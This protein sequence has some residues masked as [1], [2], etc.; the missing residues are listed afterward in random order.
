MQVEAAVNENLA[1]LLTYIGAFYHTHT[2]YQLTLFESAA[3][4]DEAMRVGW[5]LDTLNG[6]TP[7]M[8]R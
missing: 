8:W 3:H 5:M 2:P 6:H 7:R 1:L 4:T